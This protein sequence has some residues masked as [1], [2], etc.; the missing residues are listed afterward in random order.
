MPASLDCGSKPGRDL[1]AL[2][3]RTRAGSGSGAV[4]GW[5]RELVDERVWAHE[6]AEHPVG[7]A[8]REPF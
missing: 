5:R 6:G 4:Q 7:A 2:L 8:G 1:I 3:V